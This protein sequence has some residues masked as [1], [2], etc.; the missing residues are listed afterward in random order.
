MV[1][2]IALGYN[3]FVVGDADA[4]VREVVSAYMEEPPASGVLTSFLRANQKS[5]LLADDRIL[6]LE[7]IERSGNIFRECCGDLA[8]SHGVLFIYD[9]TSLNSFQYV[10]GFHEQLIRSKWRSLPVVLFSNTPTQRWCQSDPQIPWVNP[11]VLRI[12]L[13]FDWSIR[14]RWP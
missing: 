3:L 11:R 2:D 10:A 8:R 14:F 5:L 1:S 12:Q 9:P 6:I 13:K 4:R 7:I